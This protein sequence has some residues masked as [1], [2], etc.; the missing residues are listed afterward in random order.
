[1]AERNSAYQRM[2]RDTY[3]TPGWVYEALISVEP[4]AAGAWDC[5]PCNAS[6]DFLAILVPCQWK[7][8]TNPPYKLAEK[9]VRHALKLTEDDG[10]KVAMLLPHA[11]DTAKS[12]RDLFE[13]E[14]FK[15]KYVLTKRIRW[16]NL[17]QKAAGPSMNHAWFV[18]DWKYSGPPMMG[19]LP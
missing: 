7:I 14:P 18:W 19:W 1:M 13:Q 12:R 15:I 17:E 5:A 6:F 2:D 3:V 10:G 9:F 16:G 11:W 4:W 8:A